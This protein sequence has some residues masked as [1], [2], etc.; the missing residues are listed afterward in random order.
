MIE[1]KAPYEYKSGYLGLPVQS[2]VFDAFPETIEWEGNVLTKKDNFHMTICCVNNSERDDCAIARAKHLG[3]E[4]S[5]AEKKAL[6]SFNAFVERQLIELLSYPDD[7]RFVIDKR[8]GR[9][10]IVIRCN[11]RGVEE[12]FAAL[13]RALGISMPTQS[14][15]VT[16]YTLEKNLGIHIPNGAAMEH[17]GKV[18]LPELE[19]AFKTLATR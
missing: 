11:A 4:P 19:S 3:L 1:P 5:V 6:E 9:K 8:R 15:H 2:S 17:T 18:P 14:V 7:F 16:L 12:F 13:N 10:S